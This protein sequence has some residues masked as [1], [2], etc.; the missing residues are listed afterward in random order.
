MKIRDLLPSL[1]S[2]QLAGPQVVLN[3]N[4]VE[5]S[6]AVGFLQTRPA[7]SHSSDRGDLCVVLLWQGRFQILDV[8]LLSQA[9]IA[10]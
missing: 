2:L 7:F 6:V 4:Y 3:S 8:N 10:G 5:G 9:A 1:A